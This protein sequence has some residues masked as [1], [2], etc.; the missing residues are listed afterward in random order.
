MQYTHLSLALFVAAAPFGCAHT[1]GTGSS[2]RNLDDAYAF[3]ETFRERYGVPKAPEEPSP[4]TS[5]EEVLAIVRAD[6]L[7]RYEAARDFADEKEGSEALEI[8]GFLELTWG[9]AILTARQLTMDRYLRLRAEEQQLRLRAKRNRDEDKR[10]DRLS[11]SLKDF[12]EAQVALDAIARPHIEA[13]EV[14]VR[15]LNRSYPQRTENAVL[16]AMH[17]R[18]VKD[19]PRYGQAMRKLNE[20]GINTPAAEYLR[21]MEPYDRARDFAASQTRLQALRQSAPDLIRVQA[22][23]VLLQQDIE[24]TYRELQILEG[25]SPH[26]FLVRIAGKWIADEYETSRGLRSTP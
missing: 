19:W 26:H 3:L 12:K 9:D 2:G 10:L 15:E 18:L 14:I 21:A 16:E 17:Y 6:D 22:E 11:Q 25:I 13:G 1:G 7:P 20:A 24:D 8:R 23:L 5:M 4:P